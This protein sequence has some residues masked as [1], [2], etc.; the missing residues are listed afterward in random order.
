MAN[1]GNTM[2]NLLLIGDSI[3]QGYNQSVKK[4]LEGRVNVI[5]ANDSGRFAG[6]LLRVLHECFEG[7]RRDEIDVLHWNAGLWDCLRMFGEEPHTPIDVYGYYIDRICQRIRKLFPNAKIIFATSTRVLSE[8]MHP[9]FKR[10]NEDIEHYNAVAVEIVKKYGFEVDDLYAVSAVLPDEAHSDATH[11]YT[12]MGTEAFT[13][14]VLA[15]VL[16]A[17]GIDE[18]L[19]YREEMYTD[20]P[21]GI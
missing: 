11:Y 15:T 3:C 20:R 2:K 18:K 12:P 21:H 4:T 10:L 14:Q 19:E 5:C 1:K 7:A 8:Q 17:L 6:Y 16:P 13:N 9:N